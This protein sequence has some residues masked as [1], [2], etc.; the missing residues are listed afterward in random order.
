MQLHRL[1]LIILILIVSVS[2]AL[3][4]DVVLR[5]E[6]P[7]GAPPLTFTEAE[8][9]ALDAVTVST[10]DPWDKGERT[11][12]GCPL[13]ALLEAAG[14]LKGVRTVEV[15]ARNGY[16]APIPIEMVR[17]YGHILSYAMNG[18]DYAEL[19]EADKG[20]LAIAVKMEKVDPADAA[21]VKTQLVWWIEQLR[22]E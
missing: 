11:Y 1:L 15:I 20:P 19:G 16:H 22:L 8:I 4:E 2:P 5:V 9:R 18:R 17:K 10:F 13:L 14:R 3:G 7:A 6:G 21:L 12:T